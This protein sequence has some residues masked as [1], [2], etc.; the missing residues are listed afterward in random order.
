MGWAINPLDVQGIRGPVVAPAAPV[1]KSVVQALLAKHGGAAPPTAAPATAAPPTPS[2]PVPKMG[3]IPLSISSPEAQPLTFEQGQ[4]AANAINAQV[5]APDIQPGHTGMLGRIGDFLKSDEGRATMMRFAAGAFN[6]GFGG[7]LTAAT[8]YADQRK[9]AA[10]EAAKEQMEFGLRKQAADN[11][12]NL[13]LGK[14][15]V[16]ATNAGETARHNRA[17]EGNTAYQI[18]SE[19]RRHVTPSGDAVVNSNERR[20]EHI[21]PSGDTVTTQNGENYRHDSLSADTAAQQAGETA[22]TTQT[23]QTNLMRDRINNAPKITTPAH[24]T[25]TPE[26]YARNGP[27]LRPSQVQPQQQATGADEVRYDGSGQAYVRGPDGSAVRAPQYDR[28]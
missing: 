27:R 15:D 13:G 16:D 25:T 20:F 1:S 21:T 26:E 19:N 7:G 10:A 4:N 23:N 11:Q 17:T 28:R 8:N 3:D 6:G 22:R 14:L 12:Y 2:M 9:A 24:Y 5:N 18:D